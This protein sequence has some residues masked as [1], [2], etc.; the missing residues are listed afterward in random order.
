MHVLIVYVQN[1]E[2]SPH[3]CFIDNF[4]FWNLI[5]VLLVEAAYKKKMHSIQSPNELLGPLGS[6]EASVEQQQWKP[7]LLD[8]LIATIR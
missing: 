5:H 8:H 6:S 2:S 3:I 7:T 4:V 1:F